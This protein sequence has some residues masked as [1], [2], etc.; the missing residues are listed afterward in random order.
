MCTESTYVRAGGGNSNRAS[1]M[2]YRVLTNQSKLSWAAAEYRTFFWTILII[3]VARIF[4]IHLTAFPG[5][6]HIQE[7]TEKWRSSVGKFPRII[8]TLS[9]PARR[10][11]YSSKSK[12]TG[13]I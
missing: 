9:S 4:L 6:S 10:I 2:Y 5:N 11:Y 1:H 8:F 3:I 12:T 7:T 13:I